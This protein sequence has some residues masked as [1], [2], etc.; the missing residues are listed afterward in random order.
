M[1]F[2]YNS[3]RKKE[4]SVGSRKFYTPELLE[5]DVWRMSEAEFQLQRL[6]AVRVHPTPRRQK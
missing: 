6:R 1:D 5:P 2:L 4:F 3:L